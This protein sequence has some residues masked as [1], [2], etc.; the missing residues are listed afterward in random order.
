MAELYITG[1]ANDPEF[2]RAE[3]LAHH[4]SANF[5]F[6]VKIEP[7]HPDK[8]PE[9]QKAV[10]LANNWNKR[11]AFD[12]T[13]KSVCELDQI[14][15]R[16]TGELLG[17]TRDFIQLIKRWYNIELNFTA[18]YLDTITNESY[19]RLVKNNAE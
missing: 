14:I 17:S 12:R 11:R 9:H 13:I 6:D 3:M 7:I 5:D 1:K 8:W 19:E 15:C 2:S 4:L 18:E 16:Q 10:Y